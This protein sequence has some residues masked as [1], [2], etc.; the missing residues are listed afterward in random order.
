MTSVLRDNGNNKISINNRY[1]HRELQRQAKE[2]NTVK[3]SR[4]RKEF[5][6]SDAS[7]ETSSPDQK[8]SWAER[9]ESYENLNNADEDFNVHLDKEVLNSED[10]EFWS[11]LPADAV[12]PTKPQDSEE[13]EEKYETVE[14]A[15]VEEDYLPLSEESK[16]LKLR[17]M[18]EPRRRYTSDEYSTASS[19]MH[20]SDN[21]CE[22][23]KSKLETDPIVLN[24]RQKQIDYGKNTK[25]YKRYLKAVPKRHREAHHIFTPKKYI[26]YSRRSWDTQ[27]K[28]W[29][30]RLHEW[31]PSDSE[32]EEDDIDL[33]DM[34]AMMSPK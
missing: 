24:R 20:D 21:E 23:H 19:S 26:K 18:R 14:E 17:P 1:F 5:C 3:S 10:D 31:D 32:E 30:K 22:P 8:R 7:N 15:E 2:C 33:S 11:E 13:D 25:G 28:I 12:T 9:C 34:V 29:R 4:K 16:F 6:K 27:I